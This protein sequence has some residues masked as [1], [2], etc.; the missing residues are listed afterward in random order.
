MFDKFVRESGWAEGFSDHGSCIIV[1]NP[2][3]CQSQTQA[4]LL[5]EVL[6]CVWKLGGWSEP[7]PG[8]K[9]EDIIVRMESGLL[10]TLRRNPDLLGYLEA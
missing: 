5:H 6:H 10:D 2:T 9:E 3:L 1:I 4:T 7:M 8:I